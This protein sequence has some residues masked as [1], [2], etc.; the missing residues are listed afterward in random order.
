M[1]FFFLHENPFKI[2]CII[3]KK[4]IQL[5]SSLYG[6]VY[7]KLLG[8]WCYSQV[9]NLQQHISAY[10]LQENHFHNDSLMLLPLIIFSAASRHRMHSVLSSDAIRMTMSEQHEQIKSQSEAMWLPQRPQRRC[11]R[12]PHKWTQED[13]QVAEKVTKQMWFIKNTGVCGGGI[14]NEKIHWLWTSDTLLLRFSLSKAQP[15]RVLEIPVEWG[16]KYLSIH[17]LIYWCYLN[18]VRYFNVLRKKGVLWT[19]YWDEIYSWQNVMC[20]NTLKLP[21]E[22]CDG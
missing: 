17:C 16:R 1:A 13:F 3:P 9:Y 22:D 2:K 20:L 12:H 21:F 10:Y 6:Q 4:P 7:F 14:I 19:V 15:M 8:S 11:W 18:P 5:L